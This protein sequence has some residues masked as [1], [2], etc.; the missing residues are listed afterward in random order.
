MKGAREVRCGCARAWIPYLN[1]I[2]IVYYTRPGGTHRRTLICWYYDLEL[3]PFILDSGSLFTEGFTILSS[4][5]SRSFALALRGT[6]LSEDY[7]TIWPLRLNIRSKT[8]HS[9][10]TLADPGLYWGGRFPTEKNLMTFFSRH[11]VKE[12]SFRIYGKTW[13][14]FFSSSVQELH[15]KISLSPRGFVRTQ[16]P[17]S[18]T[19]S[20]TE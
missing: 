16:R 17:P 15:Q 18:P 9:L 13:W 3:W 20:A 5:I 10:I 7:V 6:F 8:L 12:S 14:P 1:S 19:A 11:T 4:L 2:F